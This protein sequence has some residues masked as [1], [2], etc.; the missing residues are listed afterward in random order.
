MFYPKALYP[1]ALVYLASFK[2]VMTDFNPAAGSAMVSQTPPVV[3]AI[4]LKAAYISPEFSKMV[5]VVK[6]LFDLT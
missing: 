4:L 3:L 2:T 5:V 6:L 1:M